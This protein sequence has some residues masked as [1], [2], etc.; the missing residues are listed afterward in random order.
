[1][2]W[3]AVVP[4]KQGQ[5]PKSRLSAILSPSARIALSV[6]MA[7]LVIAA[8]RR[9]GRIDQII[10]FSPMAPPAE[11][12]AEWW[13]DK[14]HGLNTGLVGLRS[15]MAERGMLVIHGDVPLVG[16]ADIVAMVREAEKCGHAL[17]PDR[18]E[19][20][21]NAIAIMSGQVLP[22]AFGEQ[23]LAIHRAHAPGAAMIRRMGLM[24]DVDTPD[25]LVVAM[26]AGFRIPA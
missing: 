3:T 7:R 24:I 23:S 22:F 19:G 9:S 1:M 4:L 18:H 8:V 6:H 21:T 10:L 14:G 13:E 5:D 11:I 25:D 26:A 2:K 20:G 17:A 12:D 15:E 16:A